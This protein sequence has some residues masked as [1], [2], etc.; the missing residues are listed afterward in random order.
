MAKFILKQKGL[1]KK[2]EQMTKHTPQHN[3][4]FL[5]SAILI[6][7]V[8]S[9]H[10]QAHQA[11]TTVRSP[12][13]RAITSSS[14]AGRDT[15][16]P[17]RTRRH[18]GGS[19]GPCRQPGPPHAPTGAPGAP[20]TPSQPLYR[21][22]PR[23]PAQWRP[24]AGGTERHGTACRRAFLPNGAPSRRICA[25]KHTSLGATFMILLRTGLAGLGADS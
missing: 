24:R 10:H 23:G 17:Q 1:G 15:P 21:C 7:Q 5:L 6:M 11:T 13:E 22:S 20:G 12:F 19:P 2:V 4:Y 25:G 14:R 3:L 9:L 16:L 18:R 8:V